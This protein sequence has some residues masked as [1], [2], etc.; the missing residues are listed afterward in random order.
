[1]KNIKVRKIKERWKMAGTLRRKTDIFNAVSYT[2]LDVY[3]RQSQRSLCDLLNFTMSFSCMRA[4]SSSS[5]ATMIFYKPAYKWIPWLKTIYLTRITVF[6]L[7][8]TSYH[9]SLQVVSNITLNCN[10]AQI[11]VSVYSASKFKRF[12]YTHIAVYD[13]TS[14]REA[15]LGERIL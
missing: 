4:C 6:H 10:G 13:K 1:M 9:N 8:I 3:K 15:S 7:V 5:V 12:V 14:E 2:H 11:P